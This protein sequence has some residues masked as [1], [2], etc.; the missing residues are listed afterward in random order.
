VVRRAHHERI[1]M[2]Q[3]RRIGITIREQRTAETGVSRKL[4][5]PW[6]NNREVVPTT[7]QTRFH[8]LS[9]IMPPTDTT[10]TPSNSLGKRTTPWSAPRTRKDF[11][12]PFRKSGTKHPNA[13]S[14]VNASSHR[15][16]PKA[17]DVSCCQQPKTKWPGGGL[18]A[19]GVTQTW[20][21]RPTQIHSSESVTRCPSWQMGYLYLGWPDHKK[22]K[23]AK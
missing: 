18:T 21:N 7:T 14:G 19:R 13:S 22:R 8:S 9:V 16:L 11:W 12:T 10:K 1:L 3:S 2:A 15:L 20:V 17:A 5:T 23:S 6:L 4:T